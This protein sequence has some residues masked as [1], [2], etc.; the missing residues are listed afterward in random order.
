[1]TPRRVF[2]IDA[3]GALL[4]ATLLAAVIARYEAIFGMPIH[5]VNVLAAIAVGFA[6]Y[7]VTCYLTRPANW[8][9]FLQFIAI[10]NLLY[11]VLTLVLLFVY[12]LDVTALGIAYFIGEIVIVAGL[13]IYELII[14]RRAADQ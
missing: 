7:S 8:R 4:T 14:A 9:L 2:L 6:I 3:V 13:A 12:R 11:C 5:A 10:A 1:M